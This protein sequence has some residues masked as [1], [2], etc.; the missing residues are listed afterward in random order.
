MSTTACS[1]DLLQKV[2][3]GTRITSAEALELY[4]LPLEDLG[5]LADRRRQLAKASAYDSR[6]N[7][8][9]T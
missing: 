5:E 4:R 7:D 2:W 1:E 3:D 6:G 9:V 8:I